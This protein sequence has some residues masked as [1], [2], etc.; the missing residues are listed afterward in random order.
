VSDAGES[1]ERDDRAGILFSL[2]DDPELVTQAEKLGYESVWAAEGQGKSA[3]GKLERW[4]TH[5]DDIGLATGIVNVFSRTPAALAQAAATLDAHSGGRAIL[6]LGVAHPG[7]VEGFHGADFERP[8]ARMAEY[9]ELV[10]RYLRGEAAGFD[11]D[12]FSPTRTS[13]WEAFEPE[14]AKIPIYNGAL[15]PAN[16][17]L[18]GQYADGWLPNLYPESQFEEA[19][20]WLATGAERA[21]RGPEDVDVAMYVLTAVD[22]DRERARR[23]AAEHIAYYM[24][25]IPGYY[26]RAAEEAGFAD[27]VEAIRAAPST[28]AGADEVSDG[29]LDRLAVVGT[30]DEAREQ[31]DELQAMGVDLPIVRAPAGTDREWVERTLETFSPEE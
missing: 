21:D 30:P 23:A 22:E 28:E 2:R 13:F 26:D 11:G 1:S 24:R 15:G 12:F 16:V 14:R 18:T 19:L 7:V 25:D 8:L 31:L 10:R 3:F 5:T 27:D 29:L 6:G 9:I 4:A 20:G 17:R